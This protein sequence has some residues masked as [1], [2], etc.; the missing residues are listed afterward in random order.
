VQSAR[1]RARVLLPGDVRTVSEE[2]LA[3]STLE[4]PK[5]GWLDKAVAKLDFGQR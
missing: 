5:P 1:Y 4:D 2:T 3:W